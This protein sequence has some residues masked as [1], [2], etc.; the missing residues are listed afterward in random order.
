MVAEDEP[1]EIGVDSYQDSILRMCNPE[2]LFVTGIGAQIATFDNV[3]ASFPQPF[4]QQVSGTPVHEEFHVRLTWI[5]SRESLA[6]T[7]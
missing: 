4:G 1:S 5:P 3:M 2:E 6:M 7:A